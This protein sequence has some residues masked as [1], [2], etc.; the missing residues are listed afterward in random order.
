M[1]IFYKY[2]KIY[3]YEI[4]VIILLDFDLV[5][6]V[7]SSTHSFRVTRFMRLKPVFSESETVLEKDQRSD[8]DF[9]STIHNAKL[10]YR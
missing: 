1:W 3:F 7:Q 5:Y 8:S 2:A 9:S 10:P 4:K 6:L